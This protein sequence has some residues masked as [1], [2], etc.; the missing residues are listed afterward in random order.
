MTGNPSDPEPSSLGSYLSRLAF[1]AMLMAGLTLFSFRTGFAQQAWERIRTLIALEGKPLQASAPVLSQHELAG[2][3]ALFPQEQAEVL[4][5]RGLG[6]YEGA[7]ELIGKRVDNWRGLIH[8]TQK[9]EML[10]SA[11]YNSNDLRVRAAATEISLAQY[12]VAKTRES[13]DEQAQLAEPGG[14]RRI[15]AIWTL[16]LLGSRGVEPDRILPILLKHTRDDDVAIRRWAVEAIGLLGTD[17]TVAPLLAIFHDD[18]SPVISERAACNVAQSGML[19]QQ[20]RMLAVPALLNFF[21]DA[22]LDAQR[23]EWVGQALRDITGKDFGADATAWR[24][25]FYSQ[26]GR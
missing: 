24:T 9:S 8:S 26:H 22:T 25:W 23:K 5:E 12:N 3:D 10:L 13:V 7:L 20:Q 2:I 16:G 21:S 1:A 11:A 19:Q 14:Q 17:E 4:L 6:G 15:Y 18:P